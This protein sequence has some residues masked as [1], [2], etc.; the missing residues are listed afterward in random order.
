[1]LFNPDC[2]REMIIAKAAE[3]GGEVAKKSRRLASFRRA[4]NWS[5]KR[6]A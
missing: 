5:E 3:I 1:M 2:K 6:T 4:H